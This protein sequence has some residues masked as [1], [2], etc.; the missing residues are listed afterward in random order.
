MTDAGDQLGIT[1]GPDGAL[2]FAQAV[3]NNIGR[4]TLDGAVHPGRRSHRPRRPEYIAPGPANTL[5]FT[6]KDGNRIGR[7]TGIVEI[8]PATAAAG[9]RYD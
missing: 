5:W 1:V 4:I 8:E 6:E 3:A 2:W 7:I 9:G